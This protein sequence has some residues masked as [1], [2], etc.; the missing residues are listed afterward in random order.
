MSS[1]SVTNCI[2]IDPPREIYE[3]GS[4]HNNNDTI[5]NNIP[6]IICTLR[7]YYACWAVARVRDCNFF[8]YNIFFSFLVFI[9][10]P[11]MFY[12]RGTF[13]H[14]VDTITFTSCGGCVNDG[15]S[16]RS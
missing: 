8:P 13:S 3:T 16:R 11:R 9:F 15:G 1:E 7:T 6:A 12:A 10:Q 5:H 2:M 14:V 4:G